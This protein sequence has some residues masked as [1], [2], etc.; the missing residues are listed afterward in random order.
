M[1]KKKLDSLVQPL[2][3]KQSQAQITPLSFDNFSDFDSQG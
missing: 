2:F 3:Y 1:S